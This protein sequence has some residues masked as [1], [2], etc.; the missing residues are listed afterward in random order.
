MLALSRGRLESGSM[1]ASCATVIAL[2]ARDALVERVP[3]A[4]GWLH[5][6]EARRLE[7]I[8]NAALVRRFL[9]G[10]WLAREA[11]A[12]LTGTPPER[13][14]LRSA[15]SGM[16]LAFDVSGEHVAHVS[17][18]HSGELVACAASF[19]PVGID[20]ESPRRERD[21]VALAQRMFPASEAM[22]LATLD[23]A[24]QRTAFYRRWTL[25]EAHAKRD[26]EGLASERQQRQFWH[27]AQHAEALA[28]SWRGP[29]WFL[30]LCVATPEQLRGVELPDSVVAP[31]LESAWHRL[32]HRH[33]E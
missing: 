31:P 21:L 14:R 30:A 11:L 28:R 26:G 9:G 6:E 25:D 32:E 15:E 17:I 22:S 27:D 1:S 16:P 18:S 8:A 24:A 2:H 13:W 19:A 5:D 4:Q 7:G 33:G 10:H 20:I 3:R 12:R 29:D 23:A